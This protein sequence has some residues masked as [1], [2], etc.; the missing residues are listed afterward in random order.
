VSPPAR[1]R[2]GQGRGRL[3]GCPE[4]LIVGDTAPPEIA[5]NS[6]LAVAVLPAAHT[7]SD[8]DFLVAGGAYKLR[9]N[10]SRAVI[11][12]LPLASGCYLR[13]LKTGR[14]VRG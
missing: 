13:S 8:A 11:I 5:G 12:Q 14:T 1:R 6:G 9:D 10:V 3:Y 7:G 2:T 4:E